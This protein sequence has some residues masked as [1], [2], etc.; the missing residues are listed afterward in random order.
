MQPQHARNP[1]PKPQAPAPAP[2][3][4]VVLIKE[5]VVSNAR[6]NNGPTLYKF[7]WHLHLQGPQEKVARGCENCI[8]ALA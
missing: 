2:V 1:I 4:A 7:S 3:P 6:V 8:T 5:E